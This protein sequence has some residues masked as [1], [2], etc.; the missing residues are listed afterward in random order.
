MSI[1]KKITLSTLTSNSR[2]FDFQS[3]KIVSTIVRSSLQILITREHILI[4]I[5]VNNL[6]SCS[7]CQIVISTLLFIF[8]SLHMIISTLNSFY[9]SFDASSL[10]SFFRF[11]SLDYDRLS[12]LVFKIPIFS[13]NRRDSITDRFDWL[14]FQL[15]NT[16]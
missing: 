12:K 7:Y 15:N 11:F 16:K 5:F 8:S 1:S 14:V 13:Q 2:T 9:V 4:F 3:N 6:K 10:R